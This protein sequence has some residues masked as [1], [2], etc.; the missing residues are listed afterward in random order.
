MRNANIHKLNKDE[1][2]INILDAEAPAVV[3]IV[4]TCNGNVHLEG[5]KKFCNDQEKFYV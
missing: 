3:Q 1:E 2:S 4:E 5:G